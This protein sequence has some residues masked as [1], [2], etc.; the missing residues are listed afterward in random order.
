MTIST[1]KSLG[2]P[3][4]GL[5]VSNDAQIAERLDAIAFPGM[6]ANFDAAKSAALAVVMLERREHGRAYAKEMIDVSQAQALDARGLPVFAG[7]GG[8][9]LSHQFAAE[10]ETYGGGQAAS[11]NCAWQAFWPALS[12]V[13]LLTSPAR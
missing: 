13:S 12:A 10:A 7:S 6:T 1:H 9:T 11:K 8:F 5:I 3:A 4:D 2:G